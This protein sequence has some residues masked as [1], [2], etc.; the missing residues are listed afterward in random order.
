[1]S[2]PVQARRAFR[3]ALT[4]ALALAVAY[5]MALPMA[6]LAPLLAFMFA[7]PPGRPIGLKGLVGLIAVVCVT[8]GIGLLMIPALSHYPV[9]AVLVV[10]L[11]LYAGNYLMVIRG[12]ALV[13][14]M[15][16]LGFTLI[17]A[18]GTIDFGL[19]VAVIQGMVI[20]IGLAI[21][22]HWIVY[23]LFP[24]DEIGPAPEKP[25]GAEVS[26]WIAL[27]A[28]LVVL[29]PFVLC[30]TNPTTYM[31][32]I[33]KS[34]LLGQQAS[35]VHARSAGRELLG[36]TFLAGCYAAGFWFLLK[37]APNLWMFFLWMLLFGVHFAARLYGIVPTRFPPSFWSNVVVTMLILVGPAVADSANGKDP[38]K[39]F[40]VRM[41]LFIA[42]TL[43]AWAA[44]AMLEWVQS[45]LEGRRA[46]PLSSAESA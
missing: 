31:P 28:T 7:S 23:P 12:K 13:G 34:L 24:E 18:A 29:P 8:L 5:A 4:T 22:S 3:L 46:P 16:A 30:L 40:A 41:A 19:S 27:R 10:A 44:V 17:P 38:Y 2:P 25:P 14:A 37:L 36:S 21:L 11:G 39:A 26:R 35:V 43:Y 33:M 42:V 15:L 1:V 9:T 20:G 32:L 45:R 6:F